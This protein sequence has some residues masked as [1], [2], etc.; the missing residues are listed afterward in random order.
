MRCPAPSEIEQTY[1][2]ILLVMAANFYIAQLGYPLEGVG[3]DAKAFRSTLEKFPKTQDHL[4]EAL[5]KY[6]P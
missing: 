6:T 5:K 2:E 3:S 1:Y 4:F